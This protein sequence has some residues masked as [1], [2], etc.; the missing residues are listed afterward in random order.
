MSQSL[1]VLHNTARHWFSISNY[2]VQ[3]I[4]MNPA[5]KDVVMGKWTADATRTVDH[6]MSK[7]KPHSSSGKQL[8]TTCQTTQTTYAITSG[9]GQS[10]LMPTYWDKDTMT[11]STKLMQ[12]GSGSRICAIHLHYVLRTDTNICRPHPPEDFAETR[13]VATP[14]ARSVDSSGLRLRRQISNLRCNTNISQPYS[15]LPNQLSLRS[16]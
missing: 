8:T 11:C 3:I 16:R 2:L 1:P 7:A 13:G 15:W 4:I 5:T 9:I 14:R 10:L 12:T 6:N